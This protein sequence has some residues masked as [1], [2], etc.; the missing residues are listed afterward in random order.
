MAEPSAVYCLR[1]QLQFPAGTQQCSQCGQAIAPLFEDL[2]SFKKSIFTDGSWVCPNCPNY[3]VQAGNVKCDQ[4]GFVMLSLVKDNSVE[5]EESAPPK[6]PDIPLPTQQTWK[7]ICGYEW[8]LMDA[9]NCSKCQSRKPNSQAHQQV[10]IYSAPPPAS[11]QPLWKC[12]KCQYEYNIFAQPCIRCEEW[13]AKEVQWAR[14]QQQKYSQTVSVGPNSLEWTCTCGTRQTMAKCPKCGTWKAAVVNALP[15]QQIAPYYPSLPSHQAQTVSVVYPPQHNLPPF[16]P[17]VQQ[18]A[19]P[20]PMWKC[21]DCPISNLMSSEK[22]VGCDRSRWRDTVNIEA[23][24]IMGRWGW[25]CPSCFNEQL[26]EVNKCGVCHQ[27][28]PLGAALTRRRR[29]PS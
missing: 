9:Y 25:V 11:S 2:P 20:E 24:M 27:L 18:P 7:C 21:H 16:P 22:C 29:P 19:P 4:C 1:C 12:Q 23:P 26:I 14:E 13:K 28:S 10:P 15:P 6:V 17:K 8:N 3:V 5:M